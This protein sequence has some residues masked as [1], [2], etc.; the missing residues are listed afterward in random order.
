M[1]KK[2]KKEVVIIFL[3]MHSMKKSYLRSMLSETFPIFHKQIQW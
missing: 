2:E 3:L 1:S